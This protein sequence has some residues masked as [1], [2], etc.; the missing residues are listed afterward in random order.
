M[1]QNITDYDYD[2]KMTNLKEYWLNKEIP[3]TKEEIEHDLKE[4]N[5][6]ITNLEYNLMNKRKEYEK[7]LNLIK[8]TGKKIQESENKIYLLQSCSN[9]KIQ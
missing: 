5:D 1:N 4:L 3:Q 8:E 9:N 7:L 2:I 6:D